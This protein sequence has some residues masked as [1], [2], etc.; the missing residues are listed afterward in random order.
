M[1]GGE[2]SEKERIGRRRG[3]EMRRSESRRRSGEKRGRI[4]WTGSEEGKEEG[5]EGEGRGKVGQ[6][7]GIC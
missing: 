2:D 1:G 7:L 5:G 4:S 3:Q 6:G